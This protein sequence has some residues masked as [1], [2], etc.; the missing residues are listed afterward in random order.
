M[1]IKL[2]EHQVELLK[3]IQRAIERAQ[4]VRDVHVRRF[5]DVVSAL[6]PRSD[7][8]DLEAMSIN[9]DDGYL[10]IPLKEEE[11]EPGD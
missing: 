11:E 5:S 10:E 6:A 2:E 1:K 9:L 8:L 4:E 3:S 7:E